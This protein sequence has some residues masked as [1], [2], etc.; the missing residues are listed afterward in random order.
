MEIAAP[1]TVAAAGRTV[2]PAAAAVDGPILEGWLIKKAQGVKRNRRRWFKLQRGSTGPELRYYEAQLDS[3]AKGVLPLQGAECHV[4]PGD[5][6]EFLLR[7]PCFEKRGKVYKMQCGSV[8]ECSKWLSALRDASSTGSKPVV[9]RERGISFGAGRTA[10]GAAV[11]AHGVLRFDPASTMSDLPDKQAS[12]HADRTIESFAVHYLGKEGRLDVCTDAREVHLLCSQSIVHRWQAASGFSFGKRVDMAKRLAVELRGRALV[13]DGPLRRVQ[14]MNVH[15]VTFRSMADREACCSLMAQFHHRSKWFSDPCPVTGLQTHPLRVFIG[16]WNV[17]ERAPPDDLSEWLHAAEDCNVA[18]IAAQE[19]NYKSR[20]WF[21]NTDADWYGSV[22]K[23]LNSELPREH[24]FATV[25]KVTMVDSLTGREMRLLVAVREQDAWRVSDPMVTQE[26]TGVMHVGGN[27]GGLC[28]AMQYMQTPLCFIASH[29]AAHQTVLSRRASDISEIIE[30]VS[31]VIGT[32]GVDVTNE[33][34]HLFWMGDL[35]YRID[36][37]DD[38]L[39]FK[40]EDPDWYGTI[41]LRDR[42]EVCG[43]IEARQW[44]RLW[45]DDQL[46][47][48]MGRCK[49]QLVGPPLLPG[50][51]EAAD[52]DFA[53]TFKWVPRHKTEK[54]D[55]A[56]YDPK[57]VPAWCDRVLYSRI[58]THPVDD[59]VK[60]LK[61]Y[62]AETLDTSDHKPVGC[63]LSL[64]TREQWRGH[65]PLRPSRVVVQLYGLSAD[66]LLP[67]DP[68]GTSDPFLELSC[69]FSG[70]FVKSSVAQRTLS[71]RWKETLV[72]T[73]ELGDLQFA[74]TQYLTIR[75]FDHDKVGA[76]D[77]LGQCVL[78]LHGICNAKPCAF[79]LDVVHHGTLQGKLRGTLLCGTLPPGSPAAQSGTSQAPLQ[80]VVDST[81]LTDV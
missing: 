80:V 7:G 70:K 14:F 26:A 16:T 3:A 67:A 28:I 35:N 46:R 52:P 62:S 57:R 32:K 8:A 47:K 20:P 37:Q 54:G 10:G 49:C 17:G 40:K 72:L 30:G 1:P 71:P 58:F 64:D 81:D 22:L 79:E 39:S 4:A 69:S 78:S 11:A 12:M 9:Q 73:G 5:G 2:A 24:W 41:R 68:G 36:T 34:T 63:V 19:C 23:G 45:E 43:L 15:E 66:G 53:P 21:Q 75:I 50:F 55:K 31:T 61:Y 44:E 27:K 56:G 33:Y 29:L 65:W 13:G 42:D 48:G 51:V 76:N 60:T 77:P 38:S 59:S 6:T 18:A 25:E 74:A